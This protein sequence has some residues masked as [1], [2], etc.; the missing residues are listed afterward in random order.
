MAL[1]AFVGAAAPEASEPVEP[2]P[3]VER[4]VVLV[5]GEEGPEGV[6]CGVIEDGPEG[7]EAEG[8]ADGEGFRTEG[9]GAVE[10]IQRGLG[11]GGAGVYA[12][13]FQ[14][15]VVGPDVTFLKDTDFDAQPLGDGVGGEMDGAAVPEEEDEVD[16]LFEEEGLEESGPLLGGA[17]EEGAILGE[18]QPVTAVEVDFADLGAGPGQVLGK[19]AEKGA[20][21]PLQQGDFSTLKLG[22]SA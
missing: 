20:D 12:G 11:K 1:P 10:V 9:L 16:V 6:A 14:R 2:L 5:M 21:W 17:T 4:S 22:E 3:D 15:D 7:A 19:P 18:K 8:L 13:F